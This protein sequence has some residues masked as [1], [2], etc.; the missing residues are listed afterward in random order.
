MIHTPKWLRACTWFLCLLSACATVRSEDLANLIETTERSVVRI[1]VR[2]F[3]GGGIGSGFI[4]ADGTIATNFHVI[5]GA[6]D[7]DAEF[8]D[9]TKVKIDGFLS[10]DPLRD[11]A[12]L[13]TAKVNHPSLPVA[14]ALPRKGERVIATGAPQGLSFTSSDGIISAIRTNAELQQ[15]MQSRLGAPDMT[16]VQTTAP[17]SPG[18]SGGPLVNM[19]GQVVGMN[20]MYRLGGQ[21]LNFAV[22]SIDIKKVIDRKHDVQPLIG[23]PR[24]VAAKPEMAPKKQGQPPEPKL[25]EVRDFIVTLPS[26]KVLDIDTIFLAPLRDAPHL[27][28]SQDRS[29]RTVV[30]SN[31]PSG[32]VASSITELRGKLDGPALAVYET[33]DPATFANY[34]QN[35][36]NGTL[37]TWTQEG[38]KVLF[39]QFLKDKAHGL[40][41]LFRDDSVWLVQEVTS[42]KPTGHHIFKDKLLAKSYKPSD[43]IDNELSEA[44]N[45][46]KKTMSRLRTEEAKVKKDLREFV[47]DRRTK[48]AHAKHAE[49]MRE[50]SR[51][52]VKSSAANNAAIDSSI[53]RMVRMMT[54]H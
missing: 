23:L 44:T 25:P 39:A 7:A 9:G 21:N 8:A 37:L 4:V 1:N 17:I 18:N 15:M 26:G 29:G 38:K 16:W 49:T 47:A 28:A 45:E 34:V 13:A 51:Q 35:D 33:G 27:F 46:L 31:Y 20:T 19:Q 22:S 48:Y 24:P 52:E 6:K 54:P 50:F 5:E 32:K 30:R 36:L 2:T 42:G 11:V 43:P 14:D 10:V 41:C 12:I 53:Q 3:D 40:V